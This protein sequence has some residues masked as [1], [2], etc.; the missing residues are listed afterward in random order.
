MTNPNSSEATSAQS[1]EK[2][3]TLPVEENGG[4]ESATGSKKPASSGLNSILAENFD[5][6]QAIGGVRGMIETTAPSLIFIITFLATDDLIPSIIAPVVV[7]FLS[8]CVRLVQ[9]IDIVPALGG[10]LGVIVSGVWAWKSG[11]ASDYFMLGILIN[12]AYFVGL[13]VSILVR[14]PALGLFIGFMRGDISSW[15]KDP[16][17]EA[18]RHRYTLITWLWVGLFAFRLVVQ[19]PLYVVD[20]TTFLGIAKILMGPLLFALVAWLSWMMVRNL[21]PVEQP[22]APAEQT[23]ASAE[24]PEASAEQ[25]EASVEQPEASV[26]QPEA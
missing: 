17:K 16:A 24:Q 10:V 15:R 6:W 1:P 9:R 23:E 5:V 8:I 26:E 13:L 2:S 21:P 4:D 19:I 11:Q 14:W 18:T 22:E 7:S 20:S 3:G 25:P 12:V